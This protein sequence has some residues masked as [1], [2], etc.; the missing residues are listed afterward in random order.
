MS[1]HC[2]LG[3]VIAM[4]YASA[5][6]APTA[7]EMIQSTVNLVMLRFGVFALSWVALLVMTIREALVIF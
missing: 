1:Q 7:D 4:G 2:A 5:T 3:L 6:A